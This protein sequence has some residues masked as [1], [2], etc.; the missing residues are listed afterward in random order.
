MKAGKV[1]QE[2]QK[3][4]WDCPFLEVSSKVIPLPG[5]W[6]LGPTP[7][8]LSKC[9]QALA[10]DKGKGHRESLCIHLPLSLPW[11]D[12]SGL[13]RPVY[14]LPCRN[15]RTKKVTK[16][17]QK[18]TKN[19]EEGELSPP[20][21]CARGFGGPSKGADVY[22]HMQAITEEGPKERRRKIAKGW[23]RGGAFW[24]DQ[25]VFVFFTSQPHKRVLKQPLFVAWRCNIRCLLQQISPSPPPR[26]RPLS[27]LLSS[28]LCPRP[29]LPNKTPYHY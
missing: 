23:E 4:A 15:R 1:K 28:P 21:Q 20:T 6:P 25:M 24:R 18:T 19:T 22:P 12:Y 10:K 11:M 3:T 8:L 2:S 26:A 17:N 27:V 9:H 5:M 29:S 13:I 16:Q 14:L 7:N